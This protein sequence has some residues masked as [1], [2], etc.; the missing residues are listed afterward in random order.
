MCSSLGAIPLVAAYDI[1][2]TLGYKA[3]STPKQPSTATAPTSPADGIPLPRHHRHDHR[4]RR[5][6]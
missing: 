2:T 5:L 3:P 1:N 6:P 4:P